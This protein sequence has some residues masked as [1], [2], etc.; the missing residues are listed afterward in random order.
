MILYSH[1]STVEYLLAP[2][3]MNVTQSGAVA[4]LDEEAKSADYVTIFASMS[5]PFSRGSV[6]ITS[7]DSKVKAS[8]DPQYVS[9]SLDE[10]FAARHLIF[11]ERIVGTE[12][13]ASALKTDG[14][15]I[16]QAV[17]LTKIETAKDMVHSDFTIY[18]PCGTCPMMPREIRGVVDPSLNVH[19]VEGLR[20]V[21]A[22]I[23]PLIPRGN[24][25][26]TV[27]AVA[28]KAADIIK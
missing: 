13:L 22:S 4:M 8:I 3:Q 16:S 17:D 25:Q 26:A 6:H 23:F 24:L 9:H 1:E 11:L 2:A 18:L 14:R 27:Y 15:R 21:D 7:Q 19:G 28:E 12:P 10:E 20:V 5:H